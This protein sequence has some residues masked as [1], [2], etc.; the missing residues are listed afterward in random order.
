MNTEG[1]SIAP[2]LYFQ[3]YLDA[4][5]KGD[6]RRALKEFA[7]SPLMQLGICTGIVGHDFPK[8]RAIGGLS[9]KFDARAEEIVKTICDATGKKLVAGLAYGLDGS[10]DHDGTR[11]TA[12]EKGQRMG[13]AVVRS[14]AS[15]LLPNA[16][17]TWD[18]DEGPEDDMDEA[19]ALEMGREIRAQTNVFTIDQPWPMP[20]QHGENRRTPK[21]IGDGGSFAGFPI[22]EFGSWVDARAP[23]FYWANWYRFHQGRAYSKISAWMEKEWKT[24][25]DGMRKLDPKLIKPRTTT[26]QGY[27]HDVYPWTL[28]N[29]LIRTVTTKPVIMWNDPAPTPSTIEIIRVVDRVVSAAREAGIHPVEQVGR[30]Q[31]QAGILADKIVGPKTWEILS[32]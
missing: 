27:A 17:T 13:L 31:T 2:G 30:I 11:L 4:F 14:K 28:G 10:G 3:L 9:S 24:V 22:D 6:K 19:G 29:H 26:V 25:E 7:E 21:P 8:N 18:R 12:K 16:E 1:F 23:Q 32:R 20:D 15:V 5:R